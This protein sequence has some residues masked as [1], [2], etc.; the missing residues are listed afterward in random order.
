MTSDT[1]QVAVPDQRGAAAHHL[2]GHRVRVALVLPASGDRRDDARRLRHGQRLHAAGLKCHAPLSRSS[3]TSTV[4]VRVC[5]GSCICPCP[6][7]GRSTG[8]SRTRLWTRRR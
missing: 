8:W 6:G 2:R 7:S 5:V 1:G 3:E 4:T